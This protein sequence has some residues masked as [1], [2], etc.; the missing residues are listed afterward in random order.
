MRTQLLVLTLIQIVMTQDFSSASL[1]LP[2]IFKAFNGNAAAQWVVSIEALAYGSFVMIGGRLCDIWGQKRV[3]LAGMTIFLVGLI[4]TTLA[5]D[6]LLLISARALQGIGA[7][8][9]YPASASM[10]TVIFPSGTER[11][12]AI[13]FTNIVQSVAV[14]SLVILNG[15]MVTRFGW[16]GAFLVPIPCLVVLFVVTLVIIRERSGVVAAFGEINVASAVF[17]ACGMGTIIF[18]LSKLARGAVGLQPETFAYVACG[19]IILTLFGWYERKSDKP[20]FPRSLLRRPNFIPG[21]LIASLV[22]SA[23]KSAVVLSNICAQRYLGLT[24]TQASMIQIPS[25]IS[26]LLLGTALPFIA[27]F[28]IRRSK[29]IILSACLLLFFLQIAVAVTWSPRSALTML[30]IL[31]FLGPLASTTAVNLIV[32]HT[33]RTVPPEELGT[34][35]ATI[36]GTGQIAFGITAGMSISAAT[37]RL[38]EAHV[39]E[40]GALAPGYIIVAAVCVGAFL[41]AMIFLR[42]R[43]TSHELSGAASCS[44]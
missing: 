32:W 43:L 28:I 17:L 35:N 20:L 27:D 26:A 7:A 34:A 15:W 8:L 12:K 13:M 18:I 22:I 33:V 23:I 38:A 1:A 2:A 25:V 11:Y 30:V 37:A 24:A 31:S 9:V 4:A 19:L 29:L 6:L 44:P 16:Q 3:L 39:V 40:F 21:V 5:T 42:T 41:G 10:V 14:P 36:Y